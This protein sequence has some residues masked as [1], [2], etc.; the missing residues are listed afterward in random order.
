MGAAVSNRN[1]WHVHQIARPDD[2]TPP[3]AAA[4]DID[5]LRQVETQHT[6]ELAERV[7]YPNSP[8]AR[9]FP[10]SRRSPDSTDGGSDHNSIDKEV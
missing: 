2:T 7:R 3:P 9:N 10:G 4:T 1:D 6:A 5:Y 8:T